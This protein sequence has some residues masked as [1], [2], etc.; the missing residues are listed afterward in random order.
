M[1][2]RTQETFTEAKPIVLTLSLVLT[3]IIVLVTGWAL[4]NINFWVYFFVYGFIDFGFILAMILG[5]RTKNKPVMIFSVIANGIFIAVLSSFLFLLLL[6]H[7][8]SEP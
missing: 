2:T 8:I 4:P 5:I 6:G 7:G 1:E 3:A